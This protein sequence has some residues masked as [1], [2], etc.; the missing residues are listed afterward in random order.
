MR[1]D[2]D[3]VGSVREGERMYIDR[4]QFKELSI[5][6]TEATD[7]IED[8]KR[9]ESTESYIDLHEKKIQELGAL[10]QL[11]SELPFIKASMLIEKLNEHKDYK[12]AKDFILNEMWTRIKDERGDTLR[13]V[14]E[15]AVRREVT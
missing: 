7:K 1:V 2:D 10:I 5:K 13:R 12:L 4:D 9:E 14:Y 3:D 15:E 8:K 6:V 11:G